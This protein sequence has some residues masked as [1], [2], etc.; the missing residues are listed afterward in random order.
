LPLLDEGVCTL[1]SEHSETVTIRTWAE[2]SGVPE[3]VRKQIG[4]WTPTV[5]QAYER[6]ARSNML[7]AQATIACF[8]KK[9]L[10]ARDHFDEAL[11]IAAVSER[12]EKKLAAFGT[13][14]NPKRIRLVGPGE[15]RGDLWW[16]MCPHERACWMAGCS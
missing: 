12:M 13:H 10:G 4:R 6:N 8:I 5:D 14:S 7:R 9:N 1:W 3:H 11:V 15:A 2:G 16:G